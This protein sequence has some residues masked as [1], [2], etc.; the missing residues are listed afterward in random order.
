MSRI[1]YIIT[2]TINPTERLL[3]TPTKDWNSNVK[4]Q[5]RSKHMQVVFNMLTLFQEQLVTPCYNMINSGGQLIT[6][7]VVCMQ[8]DFVL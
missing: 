6:I 5:R 8:E 3:I 7:N 2:Q 4:V 1:K